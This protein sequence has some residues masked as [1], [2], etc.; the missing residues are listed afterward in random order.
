MAKAGNDGCRQAEHGPEGLLG[1]PP[2]APS[3]RCGS[4]VRIT[5]PKPIVTALQR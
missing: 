1:D 5:P 2:E 4:K 3:P